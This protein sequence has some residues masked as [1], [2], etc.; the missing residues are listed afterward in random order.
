MW[1][2]DSSVWVDYFRGVPTPQS[3]IL[4]RALGQR[5]LGLGD[6][7]LCEVLQGYRIQQEFEHARIVLSTFPVFTIGGRDIAIKSAEN[8]RF[9]RRLGITIRKTVDC[10]IATFVIERGHTLLH[11]DRDFEPFERYLGLDVVKL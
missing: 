8:Y 1:I 6:L 10:L 5:E 9:L 4:N 3:G 11:N 7:I 2:V